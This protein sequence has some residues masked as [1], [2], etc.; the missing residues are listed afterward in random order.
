MTT[1]CDEPRP[2]VGRLRLRGPVAEGTAPERAARTDPSGRSHR[3]RL[4]AYVVSPK[5]S[6]TC[7]ESS[8]N[9]A[10]SGRGIGAESKKLGPRQAVLRPKPPHETIRFTNSRGSGPRAAAGL[11]DGKEGSFG[12]ATRRFLEGDRRRSSSPLFLDIGLQTPKPTK[13]TTDPRQ[14]KRPAQLAPTIPRDTGARNARPTSSSARCVAKRSR[15]SAAPPPG[16]TPRPAERPERGP[17]GQ[18]QA[19]QIR[20]AGEPA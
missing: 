13:P 16:P 17:H 19:L 4:W 2:D 11:T 7:P 5:R 1:F 3:L 20:H 12:G 15:R 6:G 8:A 14:T 10:V 9:G 18:A